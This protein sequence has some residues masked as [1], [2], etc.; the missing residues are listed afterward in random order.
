[1]SKKSLKVRFLVPVTY[2]PPVK[3][4]AMASAAS[5][6]EQVTGQKMHDFRARK[7]GQGAN[8]GLLCVANAR[9]CHRGRIPGALDLRDVRAIT[10]FERRV[11]GR[12]SPLWT[13]IALL[14]CHQKTSLHFC[15]SPTLPSVEFHII[16]KI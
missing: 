9:K 6:T 3:K 13:M 5:P 7:G 11:R 12:P 8:I 16:S 15:E 14:T 4:T 2:V 1:M 10:Y